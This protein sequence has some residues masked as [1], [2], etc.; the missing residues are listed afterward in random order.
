MGQSQSHQEGQPEQQDEVVATV[1]ST[2]DEQDSGADTATSGQETIQSA[3]ENGDKGVQGEQCAPSGS[4]G[5]PTPPPAAAPS[6]T[7]ETFKVPA[8]PASSTTAS[9]PVTTLSLTSPSATMRSLPADIE[10][11]LSLGANQPD[12]AERAAATDGGRGRQELEQAVREMKENALKADGEVKMESEEDER[13]R[14]EL[15]KVEAE[16]QEKGVTREAEVKEESVDAT[17]PEANE[18]APDAKVKKE[19]QMADECA[20]PLL[21]RMPYK[22]I[23]FLQL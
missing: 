20:L 4:R 8:L 23:H 15:L 12:E 14:E 11:I 10:H 1:F 2:G 22:L 18:I 3:V 9:A 21:L 19:D 17:T 16:M 6:S 13:R 5:A 7:S